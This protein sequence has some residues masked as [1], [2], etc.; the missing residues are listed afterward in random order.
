MS[1][2]IKL[3]IKTKRLKAI[4]PDEF[5]NIETFQELPEVIER[6][7]E[8]QAHKQ[9]LLNEFNKGLEEGKKKAE[10]E[11]EQK[12]EQD[13]LNQ[14][15]EFYSIMATYE[16]RI[17]KFENNFHN[18]VINVS[19]KIAEKV[20]RKE[21]E[22]ESTI[23]EILEKNLDKIIGSNEIVIK[24]NKQDYDLIQ[25][26]SKQFMQQYGIN[27]MRFEANSSIQQ[28]GCLIESEMGNID[29]RVD[30]QI[31]ELVNA[32]ENKFMTPEVE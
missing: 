17:K 1:D 29:A 3:N 27:K 31:N 20:V 28:G 25:K 32:L 24:L 12:Y 16:E 6:E 11:L 23:K 8:E 10:A 21:I 26:S 19:K 14:A 9:E 2:V 7:K 5:N 15:K 22:Y 18:L 4:I 13:L 30:S